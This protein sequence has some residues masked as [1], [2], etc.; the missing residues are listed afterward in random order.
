MQRNCGLAGTRGSEQHNNLASRDA[1]AH[2][3]DSCYN[4]GEKLAQSVDLEF[5]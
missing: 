5:G 3:I 1:K 4:A 2:T